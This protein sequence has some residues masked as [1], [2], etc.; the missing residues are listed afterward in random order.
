M[1]KQTKKRNRAPLHP[2]Q[3]ALEEVPASTLPIYKVK[4]K[5]FREKKIAY[6]AVSRHINAT[7]TFFL[8]TPI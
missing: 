3:F 1:A 8:P 5:S 7:Y 6:E 4:S 2:F